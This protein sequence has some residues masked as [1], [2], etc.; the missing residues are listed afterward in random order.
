MVTI[1]EA[2]RAEN[3]SI[4]EL[5]DLIVRLDNSTADVF[6]HITM[7]L[8]DQHI[9]GRIEREDIFYMFVEIMEEI[10]NNLKYEGV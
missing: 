9:R 7:F 5:R 4:Y 6:T 10:V 2:L 8:L 3:V 1:D